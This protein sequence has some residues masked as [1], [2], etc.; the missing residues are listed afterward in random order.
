MSLA[1]LGLSG[2]AMHHA[3]PTI[4]ALAAGLM[5]LE[6]VLLLW[7][8]RRSGRG[9]PPQRLLPTLLSGW[10]LMLALLAALTGAPAGLVLLGLTAAGVLHA[11]DLWQRWPAAAA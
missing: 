9:L 1:S 5:L 8:H 7:W 2:L 4:V 11:L 6:A 10:C 3:L